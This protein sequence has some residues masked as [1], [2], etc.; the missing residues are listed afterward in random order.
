MNEQS[1][2]PT[3]REFFRSPR[4]NSERPRGT[5]SFS[6]AFATCAGEGSMEL[7]KIYRVNSGL[8]SCLIAS[9]AGLPL[10]LLISLPP[11]REFLLSLALPSLIWARYRSLEGLISGKN[12]EAEAVAKTVADTDDDLMVS[13]LATAFLG[14]LGD[15]KAT[16]KIRLN[17]ISNGSFVRSQS[18]ARRSTSSFQ[19]PSRRSAKSFKRPKGPA[20]LRRRTKQLWR[21]ARYPATGATPQSLHRRSQHASSRCAGRHGK[22]GM[23]TGA[24]AGLG[25]LKAESSAPVIIEELADDNPAIVRE[26]SQSIEKIVGLSVTVIRIVEAASKSGAAATD[27]RIIDPFHTPSSCH[28]AK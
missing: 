3:P 24:I 13:M 9:L 6:A 19:P 20:I 14:S 1:S 28:L 2:F 10:L 4:Q 23:R 26:A 7:G 8:M 11:P 16:Q 18:A 12:A 25:N 5:K 15:G 27:E 21:C 17:P 22:D